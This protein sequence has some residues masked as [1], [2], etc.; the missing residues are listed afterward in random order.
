MKNKIA[1]SSLNNFPKKPL[2]STARHLL[3]KIELGYVKCS[4]NKALF[5][6][7]YS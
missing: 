3:D 4:T 7:L 6:T 2:S 1:Q 5:N